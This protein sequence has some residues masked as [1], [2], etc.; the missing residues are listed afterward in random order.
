MK[1]LKIIL[2][3][4]FLV[5]FISSSKADIPTFDVITISYKDKLYYIQ[6]ETIGKLKKD[7][8]NYYGHDDKIH[9][10]VN[11][12][13]EEMM[14]RS[15]IDVFNRLEII[16][17]AK[18]KGQRDWNSKLYILKEK[19]TLKCKEIRKHY[20]IVDAVNANTYGYIW[21]KEL[22][23]LDNYWLRDYDIEVL[24][25]Q[26]DY[27]MCGMTF[28]GIKDNITESEKRKLKLLIDSLLKK[29]DHVN[30]N[31]ILSNLYKRN[32]IMIGHCSC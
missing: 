18:L 20:K 6:Y 25:H 29:Y 8:F 30:F 26:E 27:E 11:D 31:K 15:S 28:Y 13:I 16:N 17:M 24:F 3:G 23:D 7:D 21:T 5:I 32:I 19:L 4:L 2:T 10:N 1:S 14:N 22:S 12:R 9:A